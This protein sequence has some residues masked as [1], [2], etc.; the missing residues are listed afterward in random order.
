MSF[1]RILVLVGLIGAAHHYWRQQGL[2][3]SPSAPM[4]EMSPAGFAQ[5]PAVQGQRPGTVWIVAA[6]N[7]PHEDAQRAD[8]LAAVLADQGIRVQRTHNV[9]FQFSE[10]P[11][12][13]TMARL[14]AIMN[15]PLPIVFI[16]GKAKGNPSAEQVVS[17]YG[18]QR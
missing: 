7:C 5:L 6:E 13:A 2:S 4:G 14:N 15:G 16:D 10:P 8:H 18:Q 11:D 3:S 17:E 12:A 9:Q 1:I